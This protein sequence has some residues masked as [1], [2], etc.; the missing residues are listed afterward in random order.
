MD[1]TDQQSNAILPSALAA[2]AASAAYPHPVNAL[3]IIETHISWVILTGSYAYKIKRPVH[4]PFVDFRSLERREFFCR[5]ELRLNRRFA[6]DVYLAVVR[7]VR[8]AGKLQVGGEGE[9][10]EFAVQMRQFDPALELGALVERGTATLA[11]LQAFGVSL[12]KVHATVPVHP[13]NDGRRR[14]ARMLLANAGQCRRATRDADIRRRLDRITLPLQQRLGQTGETIDARARAGFVRECH[15]DL[16]MSNVARI[17]G[18]LQAFDCLEFEPEF[19]HIDVAQELAFLCMDLQVHGRADL[20]SGFLNAWLAATG[21][22]AA[23]ELLDLFEAHCALVRAKVCALNLDRSAVRD[24]ESLCDRQARCVA[25][26]EWRLAESVPRLLL[27][28][29]LSG[30]GKSWL[31]ERL[32]IV[33]PAIHLRSDIERKRL[34]GLAAQDS[35]DSA[36]GLGLYAEERTQ[37]TY[38]HLLELAAAILRGGRIAM[39]D[40]TFLSRGT[41]ARFVQLAAGFGIKP[42]LID[43]QA[44]DDVL[45]ERIAARA[46]SGRDPSEADLDVLGWQRQHLQA[47]TPDEGLESIPIDTAAEDSV[48]QASRVLLPATAAARQG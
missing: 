46:R 39:V 33:L 45:R 1:V 2:L 37:R 38:D 14:T 32:A 7:I 42:Q 31:A 18:R 30:S 16:H 47:V 4:Y 44:P 15:G 5:E 9:P 48:A 34:A 10:V 3:Q 19:R 29:G 41:R 26:A 40:A 36:P 20:A 24:R 27:F 43:C 6:P 25:H 12:G 23:V 35:S 13:H 8:S 11:E 28:H 17:D 21:D 22:Y